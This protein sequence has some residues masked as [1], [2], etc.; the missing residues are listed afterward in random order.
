MA[1]REMVVDGIKISDNDDMYVIAE[2]GQ[3]HEGDVQ[4]CKDLF[5]AAKAAGAHSVK[6][7]KRD[8][9]SL[10]T[11]E[12]YNQPYN[13]E[14][15]YAPTYGEHREMLEFDRDEWIELRDH[16]KKIGI[17][18]FSTA[19][20]Y[21]SADFLED[22]DMP[23]YKI[24]SGDLKTLPQIK[25]IAKFGKPMFISTG[26]ARWVAP[27]SKFPSSTATARSASSRS[28]PTA[29]SSRCPTL[30]SSPVSAAG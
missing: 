26:G 27:T 18:L 29:R 12:Y 1:N 20:D 11:K 5:D 25:Y 10:Y 30:A 4:K 9:R 15:A 23:A 16:A 21:K 7:Q 8:N 3:N 28:T 24:A 17:T 6:L 2:I 13:S 22:L 14:N 19:W